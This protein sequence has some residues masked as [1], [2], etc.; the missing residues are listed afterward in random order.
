MSFINNP[1]NDPSR[2]GMPKELY[3]GYEP[4]GGLTGSAMMRDI[5]AMK[6]HKKYWKYYINAYG[7]TNVPSAWNPRGPT[8]GKLA[9]SAIGTG[10][11]F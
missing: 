8:K 9:P 3:A 6:K 2:R 7:N 5:K 11:A 1:K 10:A 4:Y